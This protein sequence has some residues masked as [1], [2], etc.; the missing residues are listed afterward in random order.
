MFI[1]VYYLILDKFVVNKY[2]R[3]ITIHAGLAL[4]TG[5]IFFTYVLPTFK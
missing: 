2:N 1:T 4:V 5:A 3:L